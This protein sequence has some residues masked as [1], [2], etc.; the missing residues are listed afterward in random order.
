[1][2]IDYTDQAIGRARY[3]YRT[4][5]SAYTEYGIHCMDGEYC[6]RIINIQMNLTVVA[7]YAINRRPMYV[8]G[9]YR[10]DYK[11]FYDECPLGEPCQ[12]QGGMKIVLS[13]GREQEYSYTKPV[14]DKNGREDILILRKEISKNAHLHKDI[15]NNLLS[16]LNS[17]IK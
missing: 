4:I 13:N 6:K 16:N 3:G 11:T 10:S 1:M 14:F 2:E 12:G 5:T 7:Q 15:K 17:S 9:N 8:D